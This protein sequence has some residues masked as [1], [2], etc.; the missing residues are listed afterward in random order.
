MSCLRRCAQLKQPANFESSLFTSG[1]LVDVITVVTAAICVALGRL[2]CARTVRSMIAARYRKPLE[3]YQPVRSGS[4]SSSSVGYGA[5]ETVNYHYLAWCKRSGCLL[6]NEN[7]HTTPYSHVL[8]LMTLVEVEYP[9][10]C[11]CYTC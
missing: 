7:H 10:L 3:C 4:V 8:L 9:A 5:L 6:R 1:Q 2:A 11:F